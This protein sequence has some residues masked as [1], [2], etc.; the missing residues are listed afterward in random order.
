MKNAVL[1]RCKWSLLS[2]VDFKI[3]TLESES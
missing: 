2:D 3:S 1:I